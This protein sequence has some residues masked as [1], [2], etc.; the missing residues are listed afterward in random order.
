M[1]TPPTLCEVALFYSIYHIAREYLRTTYSSR[2]IL[3]FALAMPL[4]FTFV[5]GSVIGGEP[6]EE[7]VRVHLRSL[8]RK[9]AS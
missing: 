8:P 4:V 1:A 3:I 6:G 5:L 2:V 9:L 7:T